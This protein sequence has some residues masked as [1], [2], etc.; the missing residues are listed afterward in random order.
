M[1]TILILLV[2]I[3]VAIGLVDYGFPRTA[4]H[5]FGP[6]LGPDSD[7]YVADLCRKGIRHPFNPCVEK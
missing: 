6:V 2:G 5:D 4:A 3:V 1:K 7:R